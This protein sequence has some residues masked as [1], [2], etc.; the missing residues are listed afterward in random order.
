LGKRWAK[1]ERGV[2]VWLR[3]KVLTPCIPATEGTNDHFV[4]LVRF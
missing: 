2:M 4:F 1:V 3:V